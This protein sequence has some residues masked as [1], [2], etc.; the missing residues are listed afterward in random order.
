MVAC[1]QKEITMGQICGSGPKNL[2]C[3]S[4]TWCINHRNF[5]YTS[6]HH[7]SISVEFPFNIFTG[8]FHLLISFAF[9]VHPSVNAYVDM[10]CMNTL[11]CN[12]SLKF[13]D[14]TWSIIKIGCLLCVDDFHSN[15]SSTWTF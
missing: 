7:D 14:S 5:D 12:Y 8:Q 1:F 6:P 11:E 4:S 2:H 15:S 13:S 10:M 9:Q 3:R